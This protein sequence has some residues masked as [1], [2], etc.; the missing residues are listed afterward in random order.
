MFCQSSIVEVLRSIAEPTFSGSTASEVLRRIPEPCLLPA[1]M[2][3]K[4]S[5]TPPGDYSVGVVGH[6]SDKQAC[7][8]HCLLFILTIQTCY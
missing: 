3:T 5:R 2:Q 4:V 1:N 7:F 6:L 8:S